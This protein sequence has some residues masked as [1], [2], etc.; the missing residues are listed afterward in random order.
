[1]NPIFSV[2]CSALGRAGELVDAGIPAGEAL[3]RAA[4]ELGRYADEQDARRVIP[5]APFRF[6]PDVGSRNTLTLPGKRAA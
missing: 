2:V 3:R 5:D 1:M 4:D 6:G